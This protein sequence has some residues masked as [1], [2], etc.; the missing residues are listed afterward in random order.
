MKRIA[1]PLGLAALLVSFS[2]SAIKV[3]TGTDDINLNINVLLQARY[4]GTFEQSVERS[5]DSDFFLRRARL[6]ASGTAYK[7][8]SF[9]IQFDNSNLGKR[10]SPTSVAAASNPSF[11]QDLVIGW[12]PIE[13]LTIEGGL[14]LI[15]NSRIL[16]LSAS[17][18][19][20]QVEAP[21][22]IIFH[23]LDRG[24][25]QV[26]VEARGF[27]LGHR[28]G[29][30]GGV[31]EGFHSTAVTAT[32][33]T[34]P[35]NPGGKP[36][37]AAHVR[38]NLI[39]DETGYAYNAMYMDGKPRASVGGGFQYQPRAACPNSLTNCSLVGAGTPAAT[40]TVNDFWFY[41]G[42]F[43]VDLPVPGPYDMEFSADGGVFRWDY[44]DNYNRTGVAYAGSLNF[45]LGQVAAY[46]SAYK[47]GSGAGFPHTADRKKI[48]GGLVY[49]VRGHASKITL[50]LNSI[51]PG[52]A[53]TPAS[54]APGSSNSGLNGANSTTALW[55]QGQAAF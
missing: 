8:I 32:G 55:L 7:T 51:T 53:G 17:G 33:A 37:L 42:D 50:E 52:T 2:A 40:A 9:L 3:P 30:R 48:A 39:G 25:R 43:F 14:L 38:F 21:L 35:I 26:A 19:Q 44:G 6:Q 45:R 13:D 15:P 22:D 34:T 36:L 16:G 41:G 29:Y 4:E 46:V 1:L 27:L 11:V 12:T 23:N 5:F 49:F 54:V 28:I 31:F 10:G 18:G 47:Y 24:N 20:V